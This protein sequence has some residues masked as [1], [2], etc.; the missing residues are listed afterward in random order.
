MNNKPKHFTLS[1]LKEFN[2]KSG[3]PAYIA[4]KGKIY[5]VSKS[6]L[7]VDGNHRGHHIA[8]EDLT[9]GIINAPHNEEVLNK[10][11]VIGE[12]KEEPYTNR[13]QQKIERLHLHSMVVHFS[14]TLGLL[15]PLFALA[16]LINTNTVFDKISY[17][18]LILLLVATPFSGASGIFSWKITYEGR[19]SRLFDRKIV[20]TLLV[21]ILVIVS[22]VWR[23]LTPDLL[24]DKNYASYVYLILLIGIA[25]ITTILGHYGGKIVFS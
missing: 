22:S 14:I 12:L 9:P 8:G 10:F 25:G 6:H 21:T 2:G 13:L 16:Y 3:K 17:Y 23:M 18:L 5:D 4:F 20:F 11:P 24:V 7:W 19:R 15:V 1:E